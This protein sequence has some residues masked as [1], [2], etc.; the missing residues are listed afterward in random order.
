[1]SRRVL[2][3]DRRTNPNIRLVGSDENF[4]NAFRFDVAATGGCIQIKTHAGIH[5][6]PDIAATGA[7]GAIIDQSALDAR[8]N[9]AAARV[10]V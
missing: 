6:Y 1:M 7:E 3:L 9:I 2:Y 4:L 8:R 10:G 5:G